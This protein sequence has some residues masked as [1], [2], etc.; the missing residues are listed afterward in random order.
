M[1]DYS[2]LIA[3]IYQDGCS[4]AEGRRAIK[5]LVKGG[6]SA[7]D[8]FLVARRQPP[9]SQMPS[10]DLY[11][12]VVEVIGRFAKDFPDVVIDRFDAGDLE[13]FETYWALGTGTGERSISLL[14]AGL[15]SKDKFCRWAA[16]ESLIRRKSRR[17]IP[18]L[19]D[20][21]RD[22]SA[23]V[24]LTV[25]LSMQKWQAMRR[26]EALPT[27]QRIAASEAIRQHSPGLRKAAEDAIQLIESEA[28]QAEGLA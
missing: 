19:T 7:F 13:E 17:A 1:T 22:R 18:A 27:L 16:A 8:A 23:I 20:A 6:K 15:K 11:E 14:I 9:P 24:K 4:R 5:S 26:P 12:T 3:A 21:L 10:R 25:V 2:Q 28:R